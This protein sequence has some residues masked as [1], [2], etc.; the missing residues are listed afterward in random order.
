MAD[1]NNLKTE[2]LSSPSMV[3]KVK[4][5]VQDDVTLMPIEPSGDK[6]AAASKGDKKVAVSLA[7]TQMVA[8]P[9][10]AVEP[11][12]PVSS[13]NDATL[14]I[15]P[16]SQL[17]GE[18][19]Q[20]LPKHIANYDILGVLGRGGMGVVYKARQKG[21]NRMA[22]L[23]M[24]LAAGHASNEEFLRFQTEAEAVAKLQHPNIV[25]IFEVGQEDGRPY[26]SLEYVDGGTLSGKLTNNPLPARQAA[27]LVEPLARA[28]FYAHQNGILHRDLKPGN[29]L[30]T[31]HGTPKITDF[32]LA[33]RMGDDSSNNTG[34]GSIL[35]T[36]AYMAPEQAEGKIR[37]LG[38][39]V[40]IYALGSVLY[41][42]VT[43]RP[44]F[45]GETVLDTL[46]QVK[47][48][49]PLPPSKLA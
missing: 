46:Q 14:A 6:K 7:E 32:G 10:A 37:E 35:G 15:D 36:P 4:P 48:D 40:D 3:G 43:G 30:L 45:M 23:K 27:E 24:I 31:L 5:A 26:F 16:Q 25:Q 21:L 18:A 8:A 28:M 12:K 47:N 33:K 39:G 42:A 9:S 20:A 19:G 29:I 13:Q 41:H 22:A 11:A 2:Q 34:T 49:D 1:I 17:L 38:P 44:P